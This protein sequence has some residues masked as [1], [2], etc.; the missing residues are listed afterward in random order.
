MISSPYWQPGRLALLL[1]ICWQLVSMHGIAAEPYPDSGPIEYRR[2]FVPYDRFGD[3]PKGNAPLL[4]IE[5]EEFDRLIAVLQSPPQAALGSVARIARAHYETALDE[6]DMLSGQ[7]KLE[8]VYSAQS[9]VLLPLDPWGLT[10]D[11]IRWDEPEAPEVVFG[12]ASDGRL[13]VYVDH[14]AP[15]VIDWSLRGHRDAVGALSFDL[16][17][18]RSPFAAFSLDL[19]AGMLP[20]V[21]AG[22]IAESPAEGGPWKIELG[23]QNRCLL[24]ATP[25]GAA[26]SFRRLALLRQ[27]TRYDFSPGGVDVTAALTLDVHNE[28]LQ[29]LELEMD[30]DLQLM[31]ARFGDLDVPWTVA[32]A[33]ELRDKRRIVVEFPQPLLGPRQQV[34]LKA[35]APLKSER[36][37]T[38]PTLRPQDVFWQ[39]GSVR[40]LVPAPL[41]LDRLLPIGCRQSK[42]ESLAAPLSGEAVELQSFSPHAAVKVLLS[43]R[44]EPVRV[45]SGTQ[46][47][48]GPERLTGT[49]VGEFNIDRGERLALTAEILHGWVVDSVTSVPDGG[50][51]ANDGGPLDLEGRVLTV[52]LAQAL[53][54]H[55]PVKLKIAAHAIAAPH[56][57]P[58]RAGEF[59]ML[60]FRGVLA[61]RR[62]LST[63]GRLPYQLHFE[64][65]EEQPRLEA[66]ALTTEVL[67]C[68]TET[69]QG[70]VFDV[71]RTRGAWTASLEHRPPRYA[72]ELKVEATLTPGPLLETYRIRCSPESA[73]VSRCLVHFSQARDEAP[74]WSMDS[75]DS[76]EFTAQRY[77]PDP[78]TEPQLAQ[79]ETWEIAFGRP[80]SEPFTLQAS[81]STAM[82]GSVPLSLIAL[83]EASSQQG[84]VEIRVADAAPAEIENRRLKS[85]PLAPVPEAE[86]TATRG[87][88]KYDPAA[89]LGLSDTAAI[90]VSRPEKTDRLLGALVWHLRLDSRYEATGRGLHLATCEIESGGRSRCSLQLPEGCKTLGVWVDDSP[91]RTSA[92]D[93]R[94]VV[95]LPRGKRFPTLQVQFASSEQPLSVWATYKAPWPGIDLP[96]LGRD[97]RLW[98]PPE[99][100]LLLPQSAATSEPPL[101]WS[102]RLFGLLGR[103]AGETPFYPSLGQDWLGVA[104]PG[105][106]N[107]ADP[108]QQPQDD[109]GK[110]PAAASAWSVFSRAGSRNADN[111]LWRTYRFAPVDGSAVR[112]RFVDRSMM[113]AAGWSI[114]A[115]TFG[116]GRWLL[117]GR[118]ATLAC[119]GG[120]VAC[121][122]L[123]APEAFAPVTSGALIALIACLAADLISSR[124]AGSSRQPTSERSLAVRA[125]EGATLAV[126]LSAGA[127]GASLAQAQDSTA[128]NGERGEN[129]YRIFIP[130]DE[131]GKPV[132]ERYWIP[133]SLRSALRRRALIVTG[134][135]HGWLISDAVYDVSLGRSDLDGRI[136]VV[137]F[138]VKYDLQVLSTN[139]RIRIPLSREMAS[140]APDSALLDNQPIEPYWEEGG[141]ALLCDVLE[142]GFCQLE[143]KLRPV[144]NSRLNYNH[145]DLL[146]PPVPTGS[147]NLRV[148]SDVSGIEIPGAVG[149][150]NWSETRD[151]LSAKL[152]PASRLTIRWP[153]KTG[154]SAPMVDV[155]ELLWLKVRPG[156]VVVDAQLEYHVRDGQ[157]RQLLLAADRRFR[158]IPPGPDSLIARSHR[159]PGLGDMAD[160]PQTIQLELSQPIQDQLT[161]AISML[162]TETSGIG[163]IRL[164]KLEPLGAHSQRRWLA[165]SVDSGLE[166]EIQGDEDLER[167]D[168]A[169]FTASWGKHDSPPLLAYQLS[170]EDAA[171]S[172]AT[173]PREPHTTVKQAL[174]LSFEHG[175]AQVHFDAELMTTAGYCF[176]HRLLIPPALEIDSVSL[177]ADSA[178]RVQRWARD[179]EGMLNVFLSSRTTGSQRLSLRGRLPTPTSGEF[180]LPTIRIEGS[181]PLPE[182]NLV[183]IFRQPAVWVALKDQQGMREVPDPVWETPPK[184]FGRPLVTLAAESSAFSGRLSVDA[185]EPVVHGVQVTFLEYEDQ[186][187]YAVVERRLNIER[188]VVDMLR[189]EIPPEWTEPFDTKPPA[190][191]VDVVSDM[192][193]GRR[194]LLV[195][196]RVALT[197]GQHRFSIGSPLAVADDSTQ[198]MVPDIRPLVSGSEERFVVLP[199]QVGV[200]Q[201][202]WETTRLIPAELPQGFAAPSVSPEAYETYRIVGEQPQAVLTAV[203]RSADMARVRLADY[204]LSWQGD[205]A[206][207]IAASFDLEPMGLSFCPLRLPPDWQLVQLSVAGRPATPLPAKNGDWQLPLGA[208]RMPLRVK[209]VASGPVG[210]L[211]RLWT[212]IKPPAP[213]L[214]DLPVEQTLWSVYSPPGWDCVDV[215][216]SAIRIDALESERYRLRSIA[217]LADNLSSDAAATTPSAELENWRRAWARRLV[218]LQNAMKQAKQGANPRFAEDESANIEAEWSEAAKSLG[219][220]RLVRQIQAHGP[221]PDQIAGF[222]DRAHANDGSITRFL[223]QRDE[224]V[225]ELH[226]AWTGESGWLR[227][228][229]A[230]VGLALA[231]L[232]A[233]SVLRRGVAVEFVRRW[234]PVAGVVAGLAWWL[235]LSPSVLGWLLILASL[236]AA[237]RRPSHSMPEPGSSI[238]SIGVLKG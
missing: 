65:A 205:G 17:L 36:L 161:L 1:L 94:M 149:P 124:A 195:R 54:P 194:R 238:V 60:R 182:A 46:I 187:W 69:P 165:V 222:W 106:G 56:Q 61:E 9:P 62:F 78:H 218:L 38:L 178:E 100:E 159:L 21:S 75:A 143:F 6:R 24:K 180:P 184:R 138:T 67:Q 181:D 7:V 10:I 32:S 236:A 208:N 156:S 50:V 201:V 125:A 123:L 110:P 25:A 64:G 76:G 22:V 158:L 99:Y 157:V 33:D 219:M 113:L 152:G 91:V 155:G 224:P 227:R 203:Q 51:V 70:A 223:I 43:R 23:G 42:A 103:P 68:F 15:L 142:P 134:E 35:L 31:S 228:V 188:G 169:D 107:A 230:A 97:W 166:L 19:P 132:G 34:Q 45:L 174:A 87:E 49:W 14:E 217:A 213:Q 209:L 74:R 57:R 210:D 160:S 190:A 212:N 207:E 79:G 176:Q 133:Q 101:S 96:V 192:A 13:A 237:F 196:P 5:K 109:A 137:D 93:G 139:T 193:T 18:P 202:T 150:L 105:P 153:Q 127:L 229:G 8:L 86:Y 82:Q 80:R 148:P 59:E 168:V 215:G 151:S 140:L 117:R 197:E 73:P 220:T 44:R 122:G 206:A 183:Q 88:Y 3:W 20:T 126:A 119:L 216:S 92:A 112:V 2:Y 95:P 40:L 136:N 191:S 115:L 179:D 12:L 108:I 128:E 39:E 58:V 225:P 85:L 120:A 81:R 167:V 30:A 28:P 235:W 102:Q 145:L 226:Y 118:L 114:L 72:A 164:P 11:G 89:E 200:E 26:G 29:Q 146:I 27:E 221:L 186:R 234:P 129:V 63:K 104:A 147:L 204:Q 16:E 171:W 121:V 71:T 131:E 41:S 90:E 48:V 170:S 98:L 198:V 111:P 77:H 55:H 154:D 37:W 189:F 173:R 52:H 83:P 211:S 130:S 47:E 144:V 162:L 175:S 163:N 53:S 231:T 116:F 4:P 185:N 199:T 232:L 66:D 84:R 172:L 214:G 233:S 141:Q 135:P 177:R